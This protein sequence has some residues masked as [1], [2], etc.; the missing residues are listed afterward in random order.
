[1]VSEHPTVAGLAMGG[2]LGGRRGSVTAGARGRASSL[3]VSSAPSKGLQTSGT[4][5]A[6]RSGKARGMKRNKGHDSGGED[7][8]VGAGGAGGKEI[9]VSGRGVRPQDKS[10]STTTVLLYAR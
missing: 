9:A 4:S 5:I 8:G 2:V 1:M 3:L 7:T 10:G 6:E